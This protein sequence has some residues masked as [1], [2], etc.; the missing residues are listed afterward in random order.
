MRTSE[1]LIA[2]LKADFGF[3]IRK[4]ERIQRS[5]TKKEAGTWAWSA[6]LVDGMEIGSEDTMLECVNADTLGLSK[7]SWEIGRVRHIHAN[8]HAY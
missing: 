8:K 6:V 5:K 1:K 2:R 7:P 3:E 4:I